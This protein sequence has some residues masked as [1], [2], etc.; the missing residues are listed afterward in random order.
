MSY[1]QYHL[2]VLF[3]RIFSSFVLAHK[4]RASLRIA[5]INID[6]DLITRLEYN[7]VPVRIALDQSNYNRLQ[8]TEIKNDS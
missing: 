6:Y 8:V 1:N 7:P 4:M 3:G 2:T 5:P